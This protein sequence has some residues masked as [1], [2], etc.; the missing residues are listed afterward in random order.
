M[1][2]I[3]IRCLVDNEDVV[4]L[5]VGTAAITSDWSTIILPTKMRLYLRFDDYYI[6]LLDQ[7]AF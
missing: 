7:I 3:K 2:V 4:G 5:P 6:D 1:W